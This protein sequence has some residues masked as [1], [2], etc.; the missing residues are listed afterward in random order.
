M[1]S[2]SNGINAAAWFYSQSFHSSTLQYAPRLT[3]PKVPAVAPCTCVTCLDCK[4]SKKIKVSVSGFPYPEWEFISCPG[5]RG[6]GVSETC[7]PCKEQPVDGNVLA[8]VRV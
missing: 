2:K 7:E 1:K 4:G 8:E 5:C 3:A 6:K